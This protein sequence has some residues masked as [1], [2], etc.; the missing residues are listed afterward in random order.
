MSEV[1]KRCIGVRGVRR[2]VRVG[3][4]SCER[5]RDGGRERVRMRVGLW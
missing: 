2:R 1:Q 4:V 3:R 5:E